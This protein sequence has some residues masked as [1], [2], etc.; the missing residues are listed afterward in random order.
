MPLE[1]MEELALVCLVVTQA[2]WRGM[3]GVFK[4]PRLEAGTLGGSCSGRKDMEVSGSR[5]TE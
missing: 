3:E 2:L 5:I 1:T 4:R